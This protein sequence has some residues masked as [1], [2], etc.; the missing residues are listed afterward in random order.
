ML[1]TSPNFPGSTFVV[2]GSKL[3]IGKE[4]VMTMKKLVRSVSIAFALTLLTGTSALLTSG[5]GLAAVR[6]PVVVEL[7]TS[8]G[9]NDCPAAD[10]LLRKLETAQPVSN[11][12][13]IGLEE[14]VDYFNSAAWKDPFSSR[15]FTQRQSA[16]ANRFGPDSV[17]TPEMVVNGRVNFVGGDETRAYREIE[18]E[19]TATSGSVSISTKGNEL[20]IKVGGLTT[21]RYAVYLAL[22]QGGLRSNP[23][24]GENRGARLIHSVIVRSLKVIGYTN[25]QTPANFVVDKSDTAIKRTPNLSYVAFAQDTTTNDIEAAARLSVTTQQP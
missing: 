20:T 15:Q 12:Y 24:G 10:K 25:G 11:A 22:T 23:T 4:N 9:C 13:I 18:K 21:G 6:Q 2:E 16:Y 17:Y 1:T 7:F 8:E 14:H 19:A 3:S 5:E